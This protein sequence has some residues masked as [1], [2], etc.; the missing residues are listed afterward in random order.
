MSIAKKWRILGKAKAKHEELK[1]DDLFE[2][3]LSNRTL[4]SK[5]EIDSFLNPDIE[6]LDIKSCGISIDD[7]LKFRKRLSKAIEEDEKVVIFGDFDV[8]GICAS[9]ILWET[10]YSKSKNVTPY[11]PDRIEEGY[12]LSIP[13]IDNV[14]KKYPDTKLIITVDNGIVAHKA[15]DYA[16]LK[17]IEV[18]V[19]DHHVKDKILPN[20]FCILHT[21]NLCGAGI[22]WVI[23]KKLEFLT[24]TKIDELLTLAS[25]A[26]VA[27]MVPLTAHNRAIVKEGLEKIK[28]TK[29]IGLLALLKEAAIEPKK[30]S[31]YT[32]SHVIAP[33]LNASGRIQSAM[34]ALRL[35]CTNDAARAKELSLML[36]SLNRDR[37]DMTE[38]SVS[39]AKLSVVEKL[40][41]NILIVASP[42]YNQGVIGLIASKLVENYYRPS[43][44]IS[45]GEK[46]SKGSARSIMGV[47]MI[48]LIRS[49]EGVL[50][51]AG[52]HT[53]AAGF[54]IRTEMIDEFSK[55]ITLASQKMVTQNL[56]EKYINIDCLIPFKLI[57]KE[58]VEMLKKFEPNGVG[59]ST[60]VFATEKVTVLNVKK[61]GRDQNH[62]KLFLEKEGIS[63]EAVA[64]GWGDKIDISPGDVIDAAYCIEENEWEGKKSLQLKIRDINIS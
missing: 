42:R 61:I 41:E 2:V 57:N 13:G 48:E 46:I 8:D 14:L 34:N 27:D 28:S 24:K 35:L 12:G 18:V 37:Q 50:E 10:L 53:M 23:S 36:S 16:N 1:I 60:P 54:S 52:G 62:L 3:L 17:G 26:T 40:S 30:I 49:V 59:N 4:F 31:V 6:K 39:H 64:F 38:E 55:K 32:L 11:I 33:R 29:R 5:E 47:N 7:F 56:L 21:T 19:T 25:L 58:L 20:A 45:I 9:A 15:I 22:A 63:F 43:I 51:N 44:A